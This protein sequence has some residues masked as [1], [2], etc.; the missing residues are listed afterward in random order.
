LVDGG[1]SDLQTFLEALEGSGL[2]F[3]VVVHE[4][5]RALK[6]GD[7]L[8]L[9][10]QE[11]STV[12]GGVGNESVVVLFRETD[13]S[14]ESS[15]NQVDSSILGSGVNQFLLVEGESELSKLIRELVELSVLVALVDANKLVKIESDCGFG[16]VWSKLVDELLD[17]SEDSVEI[18]SLRLLNF[19][20]ILIV[21]SVEDSADL[22]GKSCVGVDERRK[23]VFHSLK[24]ALE[25]TSLEL[26]E[27]RIND[28]DT[29]VLNQMNQT[30]NQMLLLF[31]LIRLRGD[32]IGILLQQGS[33]ESDQLVSELQRVEGGSRVNDSLAD[34][35]RDFLSF[36]E[37]K[38]SHEVGVL[39]HG[40]NGDRHDI[41]G[42][43]EELN[44]AMRDSSSKLGVPC[45]SRR[46][47]QS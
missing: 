10:L 4:E 27:D 16:V 35:V 11:L 3:I 33:D 6:N 15:N 36:V 46:L 47:Q 44:D 23:S 20:S 9:L 7:T 45:L 28:I 5:M 24:I 39:A 13:E 22:T 21:S 41:E 17:G 1:I 19:L 25:E 40:E 38:V 2:I 14:L 8:L 29:L 37:G 34:L 18:D 26:S 31:E 12:L 30:R 42:E 32:T 43:S